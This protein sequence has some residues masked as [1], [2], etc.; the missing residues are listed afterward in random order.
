MASGEKAPSE[1]QAI[2]D[3]M[4]RERLPS[5][6][7]DTISRIYQPLAARLAVLARTDPGALVG[8]C[9]AQGSGKSTGAAVLQMLLASSGLR[10]A[11]LSLDDLYYSAEER[12]KLARDIDPLLATRGPP[13]THDIA[14]GVA[15]L[16]GL[17]TAGPTAIPRFDKQR[18]ARRDPSEWD[19]FEGPADLIL[20]EGWCVGAWPQP[21]EALIEPVN[22]LERQRDPDRRWRTYVNDSL[23]GAY[24][25]LFSRIAFLSLLQ[26]PSFAVVA[27][28]RKEQEHKLRDRAGDAPGVMSDADIDQFVQYY[29]RLTCW[30][31]AEMP[32]RADA[33]VRLDAA[34]KPSSLEIRR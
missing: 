14:L 7:A 26:A 3:F 15:V 23:G 4:R 32:A 25:R 20:F 13:G 33:L 1:D 12:A 6:F 16:A 22:A 8:I 28:W 29:E 27:G 24:Q 9:G 19:R 11:V 18:D 34:R 10:V 31:L 2:A 5:A 30:I 17:R 21:P